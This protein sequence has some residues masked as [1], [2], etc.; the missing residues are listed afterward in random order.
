[1][2]VS[3]QVQTSTVPANLEC[4]VSNEHWSELSGLQTVALPDGFKTNKGSTE[5]AP[6]DRAWSWRRM[7]ADGTP[8]RWYDYANGQ[9]ISPHPIPPGFIWLWYGAEVDIPTLDDGEAGAVSDTSGPFWERFTELDAKFPIGPGTLPS[10][11]VLAKGD[12]GG[13]EDHE[14]ALPEIT[15]HTHGVEGS[16]FDDGATPSA[17]KII[18][19]DE[20]NAN[21]NNSVTESAGGT[22][23]PAAVVGHNTMPPYRV[24]WFLRRTARLFYRGS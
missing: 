19:D 3:Y 16:G 4:V 22:G 12:D 14:L 17:R 6:A 2:S 23:T 1:M 5:P 21:A 10:T 15:P 18:I 11:L 7:N 8:D 13:E 24:V 9:W 20:H